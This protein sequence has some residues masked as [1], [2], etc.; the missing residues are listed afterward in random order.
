[1]LRDMEK[2]KQGRRGYN[3]AYPLSLSCRKYY[4]LTVPWCK[5]DMKAQYP[6][7]PP[8]MKKPL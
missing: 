5:G 6:A 4:K 7:L 3:F 1:M 8:K 2:Y